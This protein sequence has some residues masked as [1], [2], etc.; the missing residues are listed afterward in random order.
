MDEI[1]Q[2]VGELIHELFDEYDGAVTRE[3][4]ATAVPQWDS[5]G[6]VQLMVM[7]E[8]LFGIR[9]K[10]EEISEFADVGALVDAVARKTATL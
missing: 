7:I 8:Q 9:F 5:L 2:K 1:L 6:H 10:R 4:T 3:L